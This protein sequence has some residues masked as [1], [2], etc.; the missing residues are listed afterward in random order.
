[1]FST[2]FRTTMLI[3]A[4]LS[5]ALC[6]AALAGSKKEPV[7]I[8]LITSQSGTFAPQGEEVLR[9]IKFAVKEANQKG[10][11]DGREV[12]V[13]LADDE[14]TPDAARRGA[15]KLARAGYNLLI[16][17]IPSSMSLSIAQNLDRWDALYFGILS[18]SDKLTG[19]S[20]KTRMFRINPGDSMDLAMMSDWLKGV[21]E[22]QFSVLAAD[23]VWGQDSA[24]F[25]K[26]NAAGLGKEVK[27]ELFAPM[28]TK[29]FAPY[30]SQ[31]MSSGSEGVWVALVGGDIIAFARQA[32]EFGLR[33]KMR[34]VGHAFIQSFVV[35]T[36]GSAT[37]GVW[38]NMGYSPSIPTERNKLFV[39]AWKKEFNREP[40]ENEGQ[41][42]NGAQ[43]IFAGVQA[44]GSVKP[45]AIA[46]AL[47]GATVDTIFGPAKIRAED[48]QMLLP[49]YVGQVK[50]IDGQFKPVIEQSFD[51]SIIPPPS[52]A[53]R[54]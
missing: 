34:I 42:Y 16:G 25:F 49:N 18:K 20:C 26:K 2:K 28:G 27:L 14:S 37:E 17:P 10:G 41:A 35:N 3:S 50:K 11:I 6:G 54:M 22:K 4:A 1:M 38:G 15:E 45:E 43:T 23:Y 51:T 7:K 48:H 39:D 32:E 36:A 52:D 21:K 8:G 29:D 44:A 47:S 24:A 9:A 40:T 30:I 19:E 46:R 53:C 5:I 13:E 33:K 31:L 12:K